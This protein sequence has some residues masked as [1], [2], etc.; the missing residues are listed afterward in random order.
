MIITNNKKCAIDEI[1][2]DGYCYRL[3]YLSESIHAHWYNE[4]DVYSNQEILY[5]LYRSIEHM[6][7]EIREVC[8]KAERIDEL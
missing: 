5:G 8:D 7:K 3:S 1:W 2:L 4:D 6:A